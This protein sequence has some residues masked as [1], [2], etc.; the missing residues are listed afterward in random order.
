MVPKAAPFT[1]HHKS[2]RSSPSHGHSGRGMWWYGVVPEVGR[3]AA[4]RLDH[5]DLRR[6]R[7][8]RRPGS[9]TGSWRPARSPRTGRARPPEQLRREVRARRDVTTMCTLPCRSTR[10]RPHVD[11]QVLRQVA[12][13]HELRVE[14]ARRPSPSASSGCENAV[15]RMPPS[16]VGPASAPTA[17][18][19]RPAT[20]SGA[21]SVTSAGR[22][23]SYFEQLAQ[24]RAV[25]SPG[26]PDVVASALSL[27]TTSPSRVRR[28]PAR[29]A[30]ATGD[31]LRQVLAAAVPDLARRARRSSARRQRR[32]RRR[33]RRRRRCPARG[34]RATAARSP[35]RRRGRAGRASSSCS[36]L[37]E[38]EA[39]AG[40]VLR[41][42]PLGRH[43]HRHL[44]K[45]RHRP[46]AVDQDAA[47]HGRAA[48][49]RSRRRRCAAR[50]GTAPGRRRAA[51]MR[52]RDVGVQ[53]ERRDERDVRADDAAHRVAGSRPRRRD[54][55]RRPSRRA[56]RAA[57]RRPA[58]AGSSASSI[59]SRSQSNVSRRRRPARPGR[60]AH[61]ADDLRPLGPAPQRLDEAAQ[62]VGV[63]HAARP[64]RRRAGRRTPRSRPASSAAG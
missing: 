8:R 61:Q 32:R 18:L 29:T 33:S 43:H 56:A 58:P 59:S 27:R 12:R 5:E 2:A 21:T 37:A 64:A 23:Q 25:L 42:G 62:L 53:V 55:P 19:A 16:G 39:D 7:R 50:C 10:R 34:C 24:A 13:Q 57:R 52:W 11:R 49:C 20:T 35:G 40:R 17:E 44:A 31:Q 60:Q 9:R 54:R 36:S 15:S 22:G 3:R 6:P 26:A 28:A 46:G 14:Q 45:R 63:G 4:R 51:T 38:A 41:V 47:Q 30:S 1:R 48:R